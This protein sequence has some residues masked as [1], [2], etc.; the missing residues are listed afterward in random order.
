M[1]RAV[2]APRRKP[3]EQ[4]AE[5]QDQKTGQDEVRDHEAKDRYP[6][7]DV[8]ERG[9]RPE[10]G[11]HTEN[12]PSGYRDRQRHPSQVHRHRPHASKQA[13]DGLAGP[14]IGD[15]E[16]HVSDV[17][18]V[19]EVLFPQGAI[20]PV[21]AEDVC[22]ARRRQGHLLFVEGA[23]RN[24]VHEDEHEKRNDEQRP[25]NRRDS[26]DQIAAHG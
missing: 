11:Q 25:D 13:D 19:V 5:E 6:R 12:N 23:A 16:V 10:T 4:R 21:A 24:G 14:L 2:P 8:V 15:A 3:A 1:S 7:A 20:E 17:P 18:E 22:L 26:R 9:V